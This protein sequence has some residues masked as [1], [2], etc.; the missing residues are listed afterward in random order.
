M[1]PC[2]TYEEM[3]SAGRRLYNALRIERYFD[4]LYS[5]CHT[6]EVL[7]Q[8][9]QARRLVEQSVED[10]TSATQKVSRGM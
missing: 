10:Y 9:K 7:D 6:D 1:G 3:M 8:L 4:S 2:V 5:E